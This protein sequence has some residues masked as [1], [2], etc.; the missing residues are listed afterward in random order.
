MFFTQVHR[1]VIGCWDTNKPYTSQNLHLFSE[2]EWN[3]EEL[4]KN[5]TDSLI[6]FPNDLKVDREQG[7]NQSVWVM[8]NSL[9]VY[10][11]SQLN[12]NEINFR[13]LKANVDNLI[14]GTNCD[15]LRSPSSLGSHDIFLKKQV[16]QC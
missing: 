10:L 7:P 16:C 2:K 9:P 6:K 15:P 5:S 1:D 11:Y 14:D 13:I 4:T 8:S 3:T 12:Y